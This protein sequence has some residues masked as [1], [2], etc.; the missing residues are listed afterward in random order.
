VTKK[1]IEH[2]AAGL[3]TQGHASL[4]QMPI[5]REFFGEAE[6]AGGDLR[7]DAGYI[8][9]GTVKVSLVGHPSE[10]RPKPHTVNR[11]GQ[12]DAVRTCGLYAAGNRFAPHPHTS[13]QCSIKS[14]DSIRVAQL[15]FADVG[16]GI[17]GIAGECPCHRNI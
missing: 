9:P 2:V 6:G 11:E 17:D 3:S 4:V 15:R 14:L 8:D 16:H 7:S 5:M 13:A 10:C 12:L 1:R